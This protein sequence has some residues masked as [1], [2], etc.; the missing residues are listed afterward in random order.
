M[1]FIWLGVAIGSPFIGWI[2]DYFERRCWPLIVAA[3]IGLLSAMIVIYKPNLNYDILLLLLFILGLSASGQSLVFAVIKDNNYV[4]HSGAANGFNNMVIVSTGAIFQPLIGKILDLTWSG[5][6]HN[7]VRLYSV[8]QYQLALTLL[9]L[10]LFVAI[11]VSMFLFAK[12]IVCRSSYELN[13]CIHHTHSRLCALSHRRKFL[14]DSGAS[15]AKKLGVST[16]LI[17]LTIIALGTSLPELMIAF[18]TLFLVKLNYPSAMP[19]ALIS[20]TSVLS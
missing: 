6:L 7:G 11:V 18:S 5:A 9:P 20:Q 2:S 15:V 8:H 4:Y 10:V 19:L 17:G 12:R 1:I 13:H 3:I 16:L 14:I